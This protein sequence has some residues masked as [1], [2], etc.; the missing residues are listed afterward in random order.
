MERA[1]IFLSRASIEMTRERN[2]IIF[3]KYTLLMVAFVFSSI[4]CVAGLGTYTIAAVYGALG[5]SSLFLPKVVIQM[6]GLKWTL[7][8]SSTVFIVYTIC[9][10]YPSF[11]TLIPAAALVGLGAAPLWTSQ[12]QYLTVSAG[13]ISTLD[14]PNR[15]H[16]NSEEHW[17][18]RF[19]GMFFLIY[20]LNQVC[21]N[22]ISS[23]VIQGRVRES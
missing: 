21:G 20:Q 17:V 7:V 6:V 5:L 12:A 9:N 18:N 3:I 14:Q 1:S 22:L 4:N 11:E 19:F 8:P 10:F 2:W 23:L 13:L 16:S 15:K